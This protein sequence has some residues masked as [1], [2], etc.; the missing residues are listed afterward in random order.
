MSWGLGRGCGPHL[1][2]N[3]AA[4]L[5]GGS[6]Q[7]FGQGH[8]RLRALLLPFLPGFAV[9][10]SLPTHTGHFALGCMGHIVGDLIQTLRLAVKKGTD[11]SLRTRKQ[12][13]GKVQIMV[14]DRLEQKSQLCHD[15]HASLNKRGQSKK[16]CIL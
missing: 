13:D 3:C 16:C 5:L 7:G 6:G 14:Q 10:L 12:E 2:W 8:S 11:H 1:H 4:L 9:T 15:S